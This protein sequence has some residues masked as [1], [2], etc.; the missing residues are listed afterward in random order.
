MSS[1]IEPESNPFSPLY[2][3]DA[4]AV[5]PETPPSQPKDGS[6][7][8]EITDPEPFLS[9]ILEVSGVIKKRK[10]NP[11]IAPTLADVEIIARKNGLG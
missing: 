8:G 4:S 7:D 10:S 5:S 1:E 9:G 11:Q 6:T 2:K 3:R